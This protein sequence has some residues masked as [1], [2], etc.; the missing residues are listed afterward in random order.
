MQASEIA[1]LEQS[2][3]AFITSSIHR[4]SYSGDMVY[5]YKINVADM[6]AASGRQR[7][8]D[9]TIDLCERFFANH[10]VAAVYD[11]VFNAFIVTMDLNRCMLTPQQAG[12][13]STAMEVFRAEHL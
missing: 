12:F 6:K 10:S 2:L 4:V 1:F 8:N 3:D 11:E 9:A 13:L 5:T 7:L